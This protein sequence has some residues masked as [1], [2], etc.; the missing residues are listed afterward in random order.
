MYEDAIKTSGNG[1]KIELRELTELIEEALVGARAGGA[2]RTSPDGRRTALIGVSASQHDFGDYGG[3]GMQR[4]LVAAGAVPVTFAQ[5]PE[6]IDEALNQVAGVV[7]APGRDMDP[8]ELRPGAR[9]AAGADRA[10][11]G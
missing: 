5:I 1:D 9:P 7:L 11:P 3:V 2:A 4:P 8:I 6:A 10:P